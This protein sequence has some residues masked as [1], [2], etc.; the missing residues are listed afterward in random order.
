[1][2]NCAGY[3]ANLKRK[4]STFF[5]GCQKVAGT[6]YVKRQDNALKVIARQWTVEKRILPE[7]TKWCTNNES[8]KS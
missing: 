3:A 6:G 7:G 2:K 1:M 5:A 8:E 4:F